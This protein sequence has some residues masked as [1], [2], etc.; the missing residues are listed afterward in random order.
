MSNYLNSR[1]FT[2]SHTFPISLKNSL[3]VFNSFL[4]NPRS[5]D[6]VTTECCFSTPRAIMHKCCASTTTPTPLGCK[7][8]IRPPAICDVI[9]S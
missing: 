8:S 9:R 3:L 2:I 5:A 6:V 1:H 7:I 4:N